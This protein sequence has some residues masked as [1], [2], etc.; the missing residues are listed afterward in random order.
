M[1]TLVT[2]YQP[3]GPI[4]ID[5]ISVLFFV[6]FSSSY[7]LIAEKQSSFVG[8]SSD[9]SDNGSFYPGRSYSVTF[10]SIFV[11]NESLFIIELI[12]YQNLL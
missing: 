12:K 11:G 7:T 1:S 6:A 3:F 2:V 4:L 8:L 5:V 10:F 9:F